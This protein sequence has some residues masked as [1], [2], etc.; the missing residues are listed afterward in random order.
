MP[1][2]PPGKKR[3]DGSECGESGEFIGGEDRPPTPIAA[4]PPAARALVRAIQETTGTR[5]RL[6][7]CVN[8]YPE[9]IAFGK[10]LRRRP[11][12]PPQA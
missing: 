9:K 6:A 5:A 11:P 3:D 12:S 1:T 2:L 4:S 10:L 7:R 8:S